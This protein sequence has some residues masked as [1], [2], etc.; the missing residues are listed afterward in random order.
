[1]QTPHLEEILQRL[2]ILENELEL[3]IERLL[4]QKR[5][6]FHYRLVRGK[7]RFEQ[8][9]KALQKSRRTGLWHYLRTTPI[10]H[11]LSAPL[12]YGI[13]VPLV[14]L[15]IIVTLYQHICFRIYHIPL[16][17]RSDYLILDRHHLAYLNM[18]E[19]LNCVYCGYSNGMIE[20]VREVAA[21]TEQYWCPIKHA[22]RS[23]DPHRL[24]DKFV[25]Y[26]DIEAYQEK[27]ASLRRAL[28]DLPA[29]G[30][31]HNNRSHTKHDNR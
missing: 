9:I 19:K 4:T 7:V 1:M 5:Q 29:N 22:Q 14:F 31:A 13:L 20:Y 25:D 6:L 28:A 17:K 16:V 23:P 3:E 18:I 2:Q 27:L 24:A 8:G 10:S 30:F 21:R 11:L 26:A 15:D 12:V